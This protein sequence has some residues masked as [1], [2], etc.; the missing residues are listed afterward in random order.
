MIAPHCSVLTG[1]RRC[2]N[3]S[4]S[5]SGTFRVWGSRAPLSL[6]QPAWSSPAVTPQLE[7]LADISTYLQLSK[8]GWN[9][10]AY[11]DRDSN[12]GI[13]GSSNYYSYLT[14][15]AEE[16][17][18]TEVHY[19]PKP[20]SHSCLPWIHL[21][22]SNDLVPYNWQCDMQPEWCFCRLQDTLGL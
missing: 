20:G 17:P 15:H 19:P 18:E 7:L 12:F 9:S 8:L 21:L 11:S 16:S 5:G 2:G 4:G 13:H 22:M 1:V 3:G 6:M 10:Y 14:S